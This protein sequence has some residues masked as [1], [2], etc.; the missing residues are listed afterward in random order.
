[1]EINFTID[2]LA[3][4]CKL[5]DKFK[6]WD[7]AYPTGVLF[8]DETPSHGYA[9]CIGNACFARIQWNKN[10][11]EMGCHVQYSGKSLN[12]YQINGVQKE[13]VNR[14]HVARDNKCTRMDLAIDVHNSNLNIR[15]LYAQL[16][17]G[18][19]ETRFKTWN[20]IDGPNGTT[21]YLGSRQS[22][23]FIRIYD[24]GL[25]QGTRDNWKRVE[26]E[27]KGSRSEMFAKEIT[28]LSPDGIAQRA[29][30]GI[31]SLVE[32]PTA[33]WREIVGDLAIGIASAK[34]GKTDTVAWLLSLVA[35]AMGRY[36][37]KYGD[38]GLTE[39]F[40]MVVASF[41]ADET[42]E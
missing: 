16:K 31:K 35:P 41:S 18:T 7:Y 20:I 33:T 1:M 26:M 37:R 23:Q 40:M 2:W 19:A 34:E 42:K 32:F 5:Q 8:T 9:E 25:E 6:P 28:G 38:N 14:Y 39:K 15:S 29:R 4:T 10:R 12:V 24:K 13:A 3:Y 22:E 27:L 11:V 21:L 30:Q 17:R 36:I